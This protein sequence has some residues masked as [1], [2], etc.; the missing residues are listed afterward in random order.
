MATIEFTYRGVK[1]V[2]GH[3]AGSGVVEQFAGSV[4]DFSSN[5]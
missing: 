3:D 5:R 1:R 2:A 4:E